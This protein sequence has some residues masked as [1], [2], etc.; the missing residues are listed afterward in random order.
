MFQL[1]LFCFVF[2]KM[3][4]RKLQESS[5]LQTAV[6]LWWERNEL[7]LLLEDSSPGFDTLCEFSNP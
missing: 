7:I 6:I 2:Y 5:F 1:I 4:L 3:L